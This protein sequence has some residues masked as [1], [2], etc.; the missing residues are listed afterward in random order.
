MDPYRILKISQKAS[1][2]E[3]K[4][5]YFRLVRKY[6]PE[7]EPEKFKTIRQAYEQIK[8]ITARTKTDFSMLKEPAGSLI[9]PP[10]VD[11]PDTYL[12]EIT[13][14]DF[15]IAVEYLFSDLFKT[16]FS[17]DYSTIKTE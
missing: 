16:D 6:P 14:T 11:D 12:T 1:P 15:L 8:S 10:E 7:K 9:L 17:D 13:F 5:A 4:K 3:I 2:E